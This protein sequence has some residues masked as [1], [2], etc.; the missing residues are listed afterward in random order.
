M[1][2]RRPRSEALRANSVVASGVRCAERTRASLGTPSSSSVSAAR[3]IVSQSDL[4]PMIIATSGF[5]SAIPF[6][7][8]NFQAPEKLQFI[9]RQK[10]NTQ[11]EL[12]GV[13]GFVIC[14]FLP[15]RRYLRYERGQI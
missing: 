15:T 8:S 6:Q 13:L 14:S 9:K 7:N 2:T 10:E 3:R 1:M 12:F 4:L 5:D 11:V